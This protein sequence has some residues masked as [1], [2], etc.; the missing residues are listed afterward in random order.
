VIYVVSGPSGCGKSTLIKLVLAATLGVRFSVSHTTR[1]RRETEVEGRDYYFVDEAEFR[2]MIRRNAFLEWAVVHGALYGT[3]HRELKKGR[4]GDLILDI[5]VQGA[6]QVRAKV[7]NAVFIF[8]LPPSFEV[9]RDRLFSR[10]QDSQRAIAERLETARKEA[11]ECSRFG[12]VIINDD[13]NDAA[14]ELAAIVIC[15]RTRLA[16]R[17]RDIRPILE[18]FRKG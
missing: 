4:D 6:R 17:K 18:S 10:G 7:P 9:L 16:S 14:D 3:S 1:P 2:R 15:Q 5:D 11:R 13:L 8:V 12:H